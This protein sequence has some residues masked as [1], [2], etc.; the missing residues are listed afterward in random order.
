MLPA[1]GVRWFLA[2]TYFVVEDTDLANN[3][4]WIEIFPAGDGTTTPLTF[5]YGIG[6]LDLATIPKLA[7][8]PSTLALFLLALIAILPPYLRTRTLTPS[9]SWVGRSRYGRQGPAG[10]IR[11]TFV[12]GLVASRVG[13]ESTTCGLRA[14]IA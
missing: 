9:G 2:G 13:I 14:G 7:P 12:A 8:E 4:R 5:T 11:G 6:G 10:R 1:P 3:S